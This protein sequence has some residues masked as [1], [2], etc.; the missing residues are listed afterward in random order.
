MIYIDDHIDDFDLG[1]A[2]NDISGQRREQALKFKFESGQRQCVLA[3]LLL[4]KALCEE[5]GITENPLFGY[6]EH[7]KP[8]IVGHPEIHFNLSHCRA[9]VACVVGDHPVGIDVECIREYKD[10]LARYTMSDEELRQIAAAARPDAAF[11]RL[12]TMKEAL[13]KLTGRGN[14]ENKKT[15][16]ADA[17][18]YRFTTVECKERGYIY[19]VCYP[20]DMLSSRSV[21]CMGNKRT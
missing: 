5:Y 9:A 19:S 3:Y 2:L 12:W 14:S 8:F 21:E 15:V 16:L 18:D 7:G 4:K 10:S 13:L 1:S 20:K 6:G 11:I 17:A